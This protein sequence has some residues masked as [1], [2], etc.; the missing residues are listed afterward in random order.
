MPSTTPDVM[1]SAKDIHK[2]FGGN[3]VLRGVSL[4]LLRVSVLVLV[5]FIFRRFA[6][7]ALSTF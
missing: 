1:I 4:E 7:G 5:F 6:S 2:A 3:E